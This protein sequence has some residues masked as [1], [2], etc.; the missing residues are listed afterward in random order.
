ML[1]IHIPIIL[2]GFPIVSLLAV[3]N[4]WFLWIRT[5]RRLRMGVF[6]DVYEHHTA[7]RERDYKIHNL[8]IV[9]STILL[10]SIFT[11]IALIW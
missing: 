1:T 10:V 6:G 5:K 11:E 4:L 2:M 9:W 7:S 8:I 3:W